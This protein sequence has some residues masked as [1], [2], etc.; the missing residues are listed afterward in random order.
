MKLAKRHELPDPKTFIKPI[1]LPFPSHKGVKIQ[2][3]SF[4]V[5]NATQP[6][7]DEIRKEN[8]FIF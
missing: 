8:Y 6:S 3:R 5:Y 2:A 7:R 4:N 1:G